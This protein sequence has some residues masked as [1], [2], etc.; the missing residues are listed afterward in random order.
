VHYPLYRF[1]ASHKCH[2]S[3]LRAVQR[4]TLWLQIHYT[5][6]QRRPDIILGRQRERHR[7]RDITY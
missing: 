7:L 5:V 3:I 2:I 6:M 4:R 1:S